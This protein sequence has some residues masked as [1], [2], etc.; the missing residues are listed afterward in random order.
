[1]SASGNITRWPVSRFRTTTREVVMSSAFRLSIISHV[2]AIAVGAVAATAYPTI[3][4]SQPAIARRLRLS[5]LSEV[6][7]F[8]VCR[9]GSV[10]RR[11]CQR[12]DKDDDRHG[13]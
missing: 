7:W 1:M 6:F 10:P 2:A 12:D 3:P 8:L 13:H 4:F 11:E 5:N 9:G